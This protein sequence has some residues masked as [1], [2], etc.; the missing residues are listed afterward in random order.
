MSSGRDGGNFGGV[1]CMGGV[2][3]AAVRLPGVIDCW[4]GAVSLES[5]V[6]DDDDVEGG[7][8]ERGRG[9]SSRE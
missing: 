4:D 3:R 1:E 5:E 7:R 6:V 9:R 2:R 8:L